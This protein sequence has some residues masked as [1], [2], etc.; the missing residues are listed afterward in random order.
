MCTDLEVLWSPIVMKISVLGSDT[1]AIS[2][3]VELSPWFTY[4]CREEE[5][6]TP[7]N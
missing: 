1:E 3:K 5:L 6:I 4:S 2:A 7:F